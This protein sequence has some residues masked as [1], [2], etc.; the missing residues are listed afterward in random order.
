MSAAITETGWSVRPKPMSSPERKHATP[1]MMIVM[2]RSMK[3]MGRHY[4]MERVLIAAYLG[5]VDA[6]SAIRVMVSNPAWT[7]PVN[8]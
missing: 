8:N 1:W 6:V 4:A 3:A 7:A 5:D 2:V